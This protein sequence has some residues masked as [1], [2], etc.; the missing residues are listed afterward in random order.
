MRLTRRLGQTEVCKP[1]MRAVAMKLRE[2]A[3]MLMRPE[4]TGMEK[5]LNLAMLRMPP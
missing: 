1:P 4:L 3:G 2:L 5:L